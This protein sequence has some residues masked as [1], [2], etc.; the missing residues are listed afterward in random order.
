MVAGDVPDDIRVNHSF[1]RAKVPGAVVAD[2]RGVSLKEQYPGRVS[3]ALHEDAV[4]IPS[5]STCTFSTSVQIQPLV[6]GLILM[7]PNPDLGTI[8][9]AVASR[10]PSSAPRIEIP[11]I[12]NN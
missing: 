4:V 9:I 11:L 10:G 3:C 6:R 8:R 1:H 12:W 7:R 2:A 5:G